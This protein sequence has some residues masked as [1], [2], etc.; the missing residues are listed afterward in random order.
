[1]KFLYVKMIYNTVLYD[2]FST[3]HCEFVYFVY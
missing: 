3:L 1:M 2:D